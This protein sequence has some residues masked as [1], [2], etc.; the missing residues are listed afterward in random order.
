MKEIAAL[1][2]TPDPTK[3]KVTSIVGKFYDPIGFLSPIAIV[4]I[5]F[6]EVRCWKTMIASL[7]IKILLPSQYFLGDTDMQVALYCLH[8]F[9]DASKHAY[10][11]VVY[12]VAQTGSDR[13]V[14]FVTSV[15]RVA[16]F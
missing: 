7:Y 9:C 12:L 15:T 2:D 11:A 16:P 10:A 14:R 4:M 13:C 6:R 8:G 5:F 3:R 1:A